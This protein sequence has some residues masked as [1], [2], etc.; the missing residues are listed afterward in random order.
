MPTESAKEATWETS[1]TRSICSTRSRPA[2]NSCT[3]HLRIFASF[4]SA[5]HQ[6]KSLQPYLRQDVRGFEG[7]NLLLRLWPAFGFC[8]MQNLQNATLDA[9]SAYS[10]F[11]HSIWRR[12]TTSFASSPPWAPPTRR[13]SFAKRLWF[14]GPC[15]PVPSDR[16][17]AR[18]NVCVARDV[19]PDCDHSSCARTLTAHSQQSPYNRALDKGQQR[20]R[21]EAGWRRGRDSSTDI[22]LRL[23]SSRG[24]EVKSRGLWKQG[25]NK[26]PS[27]P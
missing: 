1:R 13:L 22:S 5:N 7:R 26:T 24:A 18:D 17:L 9:R 8:P 15:E 11:P 4:A 25:S 16:C 20:P 27:Y 6:S 3:R 2:R 19:L 21:V 14:M 10:W 23:L 12:S